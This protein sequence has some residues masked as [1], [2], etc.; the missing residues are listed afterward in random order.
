MSAFVRDIADSSLLEGVSVEFFFDSNGSNI[1]M[2]SS[3]TD[4]NGTA[5]L[6]WTAAGISPGS[7]QIL[8]LVA[9]SLTDPLAKGNSRYTGNI[10][11]E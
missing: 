5:N 7:Y 2:G 10:T 3:L 11:P 4:E 8:A 6:T 9:D 1:S